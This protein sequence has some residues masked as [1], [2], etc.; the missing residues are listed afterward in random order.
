MTSKI[1][2]PV[3]EKQL[4][5]M[6]ILSEEFVSGTSIEKALTKFDSPNTP[7]SFDML[8]EAAELNLM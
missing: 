2:E 5:G 4:K 7:C 3:L 8:G 6:D 1:G